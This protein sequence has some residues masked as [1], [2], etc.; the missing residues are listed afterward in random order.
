M[1]Y[2]LMVAGALACVVVAF[3]AIELGRSDDDAAV[4]VPSVLAEV[5]SQREATLAPDLIE[6]SEPSAGAAITSPLKVSGSV[7]AAG[8]TFYISLV[9]A[10][11]THVID[12]PVHT[13]TP[14][15][16]VPFEQQIPFSYFE[17]TPACVWVYREN[18]D[19]AETVRIPVVIQPQASPTN[20]GQ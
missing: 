20:G 6:I 1:R 7:N 12:Y 13:N 4:P 15:T 8:G 11:G 16:L 10:D 18:I 17:Q 14:D 3:V 9:T 2:V 19:G 5:C